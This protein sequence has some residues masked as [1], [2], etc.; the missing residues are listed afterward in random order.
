MNSSLTRIFRA[1][2]ILDEDPL[3]VRFLRDRRT[4]DERADV[5]VT[6]DATQLLVEGKQLR[7]ER[8]RDRLV[9]LDQIAVVAREVVEG[10][11]ALHPRDLRAS[12]RNDL[13]ADERGIDGDPHSAEHL[14]EMAECLHASLQLLD[15]R[16]VAST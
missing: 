7:N 6:G 12:V 4:V 13:S 5:G 8:I 15:R 14:R 2:E 16:A 3:S 10:L 9:V 11:F 1:L